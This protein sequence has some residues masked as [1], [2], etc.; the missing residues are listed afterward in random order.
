[1]HRPL[2]FDAALRVV[3][4]VFKAKARLKHNSGLSCHGHS[5]LE[6]LVSPAASGDSAHI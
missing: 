3:L 6:A 5:A 2:C 1:M 4:A